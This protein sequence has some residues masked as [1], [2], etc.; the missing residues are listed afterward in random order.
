MMNTART[1]FFFA[2]MLLAAPA[3]SAQDA[4]P[5]APV[6]TGSTSLLD[7]YTQGGWTM[8]FLLLFSVGTVAVAVYCFTQVTQGKMV[9]KALSDTLTRS[10]QSRDV[11]GA[12]QM[13]LAQP[14]SLSRV[15]S[16]AL[17]K[18]NFDR[19]QANKTSMEDA[20]GEAMDFEETRLMT[21]I[22]YLNVFATIAPMVGLYGTVSGMITAFNKLKAGQSEPA[23]LAG[24]IGEAMITTAGG[25]IV[26][27][28]A[29]FLFFFFRTKLSGIMSELQRNASFLIGVLSGEV[30]LAGSTE[31][32]QASEESN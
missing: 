10:M 1:L 12:Y 32:A 23:D 17:L 6:E 25:L 7:L 4:K 16:S 11:G 28:P 24:G 29:M 9:P 5:D 14:N 8:H 21:W 15:V 20:A 2:A 26:G 3:L 18:V 22:N 27:I 13:C 19:D 31:P 30:K